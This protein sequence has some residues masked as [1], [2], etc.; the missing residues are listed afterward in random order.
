MELVS[1]QRRAP[2]GAPREAPGQGAAADRE[3]EGDEDQGRRAREGE[4]HPGANGP[5]R[6]ACAAIR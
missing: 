3:G 1:L 5:V 6:D 4:P 2:K